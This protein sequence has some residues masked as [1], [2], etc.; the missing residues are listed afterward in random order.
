MRQKIKYLLYL[1]IGGISS[2][3][4]IFCI[5]SCSEKTDYWVQCN[6]I[7]SNNSG[8]SINLLVYNN[9]KKLIKTYYI[10]SNDSLSI[11]LKGEGGAGPFQFTTFADMQGD[12]ALIEFSDIKRIS[13]KSGTG[14]LYLGNYETTKQSNTLY[15][16]RYNITKEDHDKAD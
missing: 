3:L 1:I 10:L 6:Y 9:S 16:S 12:S 8:F 13:Y 14:I 11:L 4:T 5:N 15:T 7:Y 2:I